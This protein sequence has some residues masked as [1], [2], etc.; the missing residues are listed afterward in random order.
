MDEDYEREFVQKFSNAEKA[1]SKTEWLPSILLHRRAA[2]SDV[3]KLET[4]MGIAFPSDFRHILLEH[5]G[6]IPYPR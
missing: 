5:Q 6:H 2:E 3:A 4:K 1:M